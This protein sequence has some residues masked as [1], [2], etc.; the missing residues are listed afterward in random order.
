MKLNS[1]THLVKTDQPD[2]FN[3]QWLDGCLIAGATGVAARIGADLVRINY[4]KKADSESSE[5][6]K[7]AVLATDRTKVVCAVGSSDDVESFLKRLYDQIQVGGA[8]ENA[9]GRN[10]YQKS[11][12]ETIRMCNAVYAIRMEKKNVEEAMK[13]YNSA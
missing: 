13:I 7:E 10:I 6:L 8:A 2:P 3:D 1:K 4:P 12:N 5:I 11:L 9:A